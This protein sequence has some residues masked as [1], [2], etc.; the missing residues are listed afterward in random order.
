MLILLLIYLIFLL[1]YVVFSIYSILRIW[2]LR[3]KGDKSG[4]L[5]LTY[6]ITVVLVTAISL[7]FIANLSWKTN[8]NFSI[9]GISGR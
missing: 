7:I 3:L 4:V 1:V 6:M 9:G 2:S 5:V 8:F